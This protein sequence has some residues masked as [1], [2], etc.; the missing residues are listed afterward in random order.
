MF[1]VQDEVMIPKTRMKQQTNKQNW[2]TGHLKRMKFCYPIFTDAMKWTYLKFHVKENG[3]LQLL[4][5][6]ECPLE[7]SPTPTKR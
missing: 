4:V 5:V 7:Y 2:D 6:T 1:I 3:Q